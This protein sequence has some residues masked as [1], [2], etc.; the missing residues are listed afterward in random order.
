MIDFVE[1]VRVQKDAEKTLDNILS[2]R[3]ENFEQYEE[4]TKIKDIEVAKIIIK[5]LLDKIN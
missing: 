1:K 3:Y 2:K 4:V 5:R